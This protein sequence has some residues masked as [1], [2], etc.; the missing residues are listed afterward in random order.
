MHLVR[1][2][3]SFLFTWILVVGFFWPS[4]VVHANAA[5]V[6]PERASS[7]IQ[8]VQQ[9]LLAKPGDMQLSFAL[10]MAYQSIKKYDTAARIFRGMLRVDP[11]AARPRLELAYS[12][13]ALEQYDEALFHFEHLKATK[14]PIEVKLSVKHFIDQIRLTKPS[15]NYEISLI[16]NDNPNK[17]TSSDDIMMRGLRYSLSAD[18]QKQTVKGVKT[19]FDAHIPLN[20]DRHF[21][22]GVGVEHNEYDLKSMNLTSVHT[23]FGHKKKLG[24]AL[25]TS[26]L[27]LVVAEYGKA[28][29]YHGHFLSIES[30]T[31]IS[32]KAN[33][34][35]SLSAQKLEY[36]DE[37]VGYDVTS[38]NYEVGIESSSDV[39]WHQI[40]KV[41]YLKYPAQYRFNAFD[42]SYASALISK[43][44][45]GGWRAWT[46]FLMQNKKFYGEDPLFGLTRKDRVNNLILGLA[47]TDL[48]LR[49][50]TP[51]ILFTNSLGR[52]NIELHRYKQNTISLIFGKVF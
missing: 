15:F 2:N 18:A 7:I 51:K 14:L 4:G 41:G 19:V 27:G 11:Y 25:L 37:Y 28:P 9:E 1:R 6:T 33:L 17:T 52:S 8:E 5:K 22:T 26:K 10:G 47:N 40:I 16:S 44:F 29:L 36:A 50:W 32:G 45:S 39:T 20:T 31:P 23:V 49:G 30:I 13:F 12:L 38:K 46:E 34:M 43:E 21:F 35:M 42:E 3:K 48:N 24:D